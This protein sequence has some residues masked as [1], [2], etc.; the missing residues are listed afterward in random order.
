MP[1]PPRLAFEA[2]SLQA[3]QLTLQAE[4]EAKLRAIKHFDRVLAHLSLEP[5]AESAREDVALLL[6]QINGMLGA[7]ATVRTLLIDL[8]RTT[9]AL[10]RQLRHTR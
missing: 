5:N 6:A 2:E 3:N 7:N 8:R 9:K 10:A 4:V 1:V